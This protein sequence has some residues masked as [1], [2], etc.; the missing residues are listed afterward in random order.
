MHVPNVLQLGRA[1]APESA[2]LAS[3]T[4]L[5]DAVRDGQKSISRELYG[6]LGLP[7]DATNI[8]RLLEKISESV[9]NKTPCLISTPNVNFLVES[10]SNRRFRES[11]L[12]SD[13]CLID[14]MPIVW[15]ARMLGV[16]VKERIAGSDLFN[17]L[18][19]H[20]SSRLKVF[21]FGGADGVAETVRNKLNSEARG[22]ECVGALNPGFGTIEDLSSSQIIDAVNASKADLLAVFLGAAKGQE[23]LLRNHH[24]IKIPVRCHFGA[25][26]NFE[27]GSVKRAPLFLQRA[28]VEWLWRI[29]EE[30]Y[31]WRRYWND[32][33]RFLYLLLSCAF[34]LFAKR[35]W[36]QFW[37]ARGHDQFA[38]DRIDGIKS[39]TIILQ[40]E[41]TAK[42]IQSAIS[43]FRDAFVMEKEIIVDISKVGAVDPRFFGF[44]LALRKHLTDQGGHLSFVGVVPAMER[45]FRMNGFEFLLNSE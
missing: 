30:P 34:P 17:V 7:V 10:R 18:K 21:L 31:L 27:A 39:T 40:G 20:G 14:G 42:Q 44:F 23:W 12:M 8:E 6:V 43:Y 33:I 29:K 3:M 26:I 25:T 11:L 1:P 32:G 41:L 38:I 28:G 5:G 9:A 4:V 24:R 13:L 19:S 45:A 15:V 22:L 16:P 36:R 2:E 35:K 37:R